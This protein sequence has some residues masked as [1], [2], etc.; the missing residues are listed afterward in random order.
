M[1]TGKLSSEDAIEGVM[2]FLEERDPTWKRR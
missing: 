1:R 2:A